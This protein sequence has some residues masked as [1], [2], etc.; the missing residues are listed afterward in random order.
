MSTLHPEPSWRARPSPRRSRQILL[1]VLAAVWSYAA[2]PVLADPVITEFMASNAT[3]IA[4]EDGSYEDW[5]ELHNPT[6]APINIGGWHL[7]DSASNK[8]K[9]TFPAGVTVPANGYLL[10]WASNKNR[11]SATTPL[12]TN[13]ALSANGEY[14]GL[15]KADGTVVS[16]YAPTYPPQSSDVSYG[17]TQP[18]DAN[19]APQIGYFATPT[20]GARNGGSDTLVTLGNVTLSSGGGTFTGSM[21]LEI[22]GAEAGQTIRYTLTA[23]SESGA[24]APAPTASSPAYTGPITLDES[25]IVKAALFADAVRG[26]VTTAHF[27]RISNISNFTSRLPILIMDNHGLGPMVKDEIDRDGWMHI[28]NLNGNQPASLARQPDVS[29]PMT[30]KVRGSSSASFPKKAFNVE[31]KRVMGGDNP[32]P[33]LGMPANDRWSLIA[34]WLYDP[35]FIRNAYVY[36]LSNSI[37]RWAP[38]TRFAE[39]FLNVNGGPV[40]ESDYHG[41]VIVTDRI[42]VHP[43]RVDITPGVPGATSEPEITG[44]Y[45]FKLDEADPDEYA[46]KTNRAIPSG[47]YGEQ[48]VVARPKL[49]D[50]SDAQRDYVRNYFQQ[51]EDALYADATGNFQ[52]RNYLNFLDRDSWVD[53]HMIQVFVG[54]ADGLLRSVYFYKDREGKLIAGPQWDFDR[55]AGSKD[56]RVTRWDLWTLAGHGDVPGGGGVNVWEHD[57]WGQIARDPDFRQ[58]WVDRWQ[59]Y[60]RGPF[61]DE[62][63]QQLAFDLGDQIGA[64]AAHRD[65]ARWPDNASRFAGG[66]PGEVQHLAEWMT[67]RAQWIDE[68]FVAPPTVTLDGDEATLTPA[69]GS[70]VLFTLDGSD[71]RLPGGGRSVQ[72]HVSDHA[73]TV[74]STSNFRARNYNASLEDSIPGSA[75]SS[76]IS[77]ADLVPGDED[78]DARLVNV[79]S[80]AYTGTGENVVIAGIVIA[81]SEPA[82]YLVRAVGPTLAGMGVEGTLSDPTLQVVNAQGTVVAE[83]RIWSADD[84]ASLREIMASVGAF[85]LPNNSTD[86]AL[87]AELTSGAYTVIVRN[88]A[89][90][91]G[92][93]LA[94]IYQVDRNGSRPINL[95]TRARVRGG[96]ER[97]IG[98]IVVQGD[99]PKRLLIRAVG[100]SLAGLGVNDV[101]PDPILHI[102]H[103]SERIAEVNDW[104]ATP[105]LLE[106]TAAAG[107]FTLDDNSK[108]AAI[109]L[110]LPPGNY[111]AIVSSQEGHE[112]VALVEVYEIP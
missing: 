55:A 71:P 15:I 106:A 83:N 75:W 52:T 99:T 51:M 26:P 53:Y 100:P 18:T 89:A 66:Y 32:V 38:R 67:L 39:V 40:D 42:L 3:T 73:V 50:L 60:R 34:P 7:T 47:I 14:L 65:A 5:V 91:T 95:S 23:P 54:N 27:A 105:E 25:V 1:T 68:Q 21:L 35:A 84:A 93:S 90:G 87:V 58:A 9:W 37:G 48:V 22:S 92:I 13:W 36:S 59:Q 107:A 64:D 81:G 17:I 104:E 97:L 88:A 94:E 57:W 43:N 78:S 102:H 24:A 63:L 82:R 96:D 16:E 8:T 33:L 19:E 80:R 110:V 101:L 31:L 74:P 98:G 109:V 12:H 85:E 6:A 44:G 76:A 62:R 29:T 28:Y 69:P 86:A 77:L 11:G 111:T 70:Q 4:D 103:G 20:P 108:D 56:P 41:I 10:V 112:G 72:A 79:S 30:F 46:F 45:I 2:T 49:A 61:S